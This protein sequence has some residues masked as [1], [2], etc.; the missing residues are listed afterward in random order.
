MNNKEVRHSIESI[1]KALESCSYGIN[2][3]EFVMNIIGIRNLELQSKPKFVD[4]ICIIINVYGSIKYFEVSATT[5]PGVD[6]ILDCRKYGTDFILP[7][8]YYRNLW[9]LGYDNKF[10]QYTPVVAIHAKHKK[11]RFLDYSE[12]IN[13]N[14][15][16]ARGVELKQLKFLLKVNKVSDGLGQLVERISDMN[17]ILSYAVMQKN[18]KNTR[19]FNYILMDEVDGHLTATDKI[20]GEELWRPE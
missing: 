17:I 6:E 19:F 13:N 8:G 1:E 18:A 10:N 14:F 15:Q 4:K 9:K 5:K 16:T 2:K 11:R 3:D 12:F 7:T 20:Y